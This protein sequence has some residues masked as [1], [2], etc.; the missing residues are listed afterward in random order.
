ML[1]GDEIE[2]VTSSAFAEVTE[3]VDKNLPTKKTSVLND[4]TGFVLPNI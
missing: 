3:S 4:Y 1:T 2:N